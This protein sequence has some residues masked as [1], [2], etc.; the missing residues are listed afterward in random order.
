MTFFEGFLV[1]GA[2]LLA[3]DADVQITQTD[4]DASDAGRDESGFMHRQIVRHRVKT[5]AFR[6]SALTAQ[7][8]GYLEDLFTGKA[9][10]T[11]T[12]PGF[13]GRQATCQA[14]CSKD[15]I[16]YHNARTGLYKNNQFTVI[17][18]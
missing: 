17:E 13:D 12:Y 16:S 15:S 18:C 8:L 7:E 4:L 2:P 1:D 3:P 14:Y 6:Y 5:W 10:F 11:F 9:T